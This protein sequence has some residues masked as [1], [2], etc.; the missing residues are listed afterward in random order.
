M[1]DVGINSKPDKGP[2]GY[3]LC[4]DVD[5]EEASKVH[6]RRSTRRVAPA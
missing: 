6:R 2:K 4:G 3:K 5:F 1:I